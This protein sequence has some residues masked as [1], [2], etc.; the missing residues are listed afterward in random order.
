METNYY[1]FF[2]ISFQHKTEYF[3]ELISIKFGQVSF[4]LFEKFFDPVVI[5]REIEVHFESQWIS[6]K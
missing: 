3:S 2:V 4:V 5:D 6:S 1:I